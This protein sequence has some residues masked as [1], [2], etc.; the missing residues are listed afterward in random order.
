[1]DTPSGTTK[2][3]QRLACRLGRPLGNVPPA[4]SGPQRGAE[5]CL[6][7]RG[8]RCPVGTVLRRSPL[9]RPSVLDAPH[10]GAG[11]EPAGETVPPE[12]AE[13]VPTPCPL[14]RLYFFERGGCVGAGGG[15]LFS[16]YRFYKGAPVSA[17]ASVGPGR[18]PPG[19]R[20]P[21]PRKGT[22]SLRPTAK[23]VSKGRDGGLAEPGRGAVF[24]E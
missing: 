22:L 13:G 11:P 16:K 20:T 19:T 18:C 5:T 6:P 2:S 24:G 12:A 17:A 14:P 7:L 4:R 1:M 10:W 15:V 8:R 21:F 23:K 9:P 3:C